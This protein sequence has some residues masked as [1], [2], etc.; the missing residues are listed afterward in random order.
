M[1]KKNFVYTL[2]VTFI[3]GL[4]MGGFLTGAVTGQFFRRPVPTT[5]SVSPK[6]VIIGNTDEISEL[7]IKI[8][9]GNRGSE[10]IY[11]IRRDDPYRDDEKDLKIIEDQWCKGMDDFGNPVIKTGSD[12]GSKCFSQKTFTYSFPTRGFFEGNAYYAKVYDFATK[13][14]V[15][16][17][18]KVRVYETP[19]AGASR[20]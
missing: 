18:F 15:K 14:Y 8:T 13:S 9:P 1:E 10:A 16:S 7:T 20:S 3:V 6:E 11:E 5:I 4:F 2:V 17:Y 19:D 12:R